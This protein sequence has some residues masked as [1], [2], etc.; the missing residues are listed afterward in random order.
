MLLSV[1]IRQR[2]I[3]LSKEHNLNFSELCRKS[4]VSYSTLMGFMYDTNKTLTI[5][6]LYQ[7]CISFVLV[8]KLTLLIFLI[9]ICLK[10]FL[11]S[12]KRLGNNYET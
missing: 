1:A 10:M 6:T 7:L 5:N 12:M 2:I 11:M 4:D 8:L 9:L 3:N